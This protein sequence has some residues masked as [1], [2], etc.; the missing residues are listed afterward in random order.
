MNFLSAVNT[1]HSRNKKNRK[2]ITNEIT[3]QMAT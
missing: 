2:K 3:G 1:Y